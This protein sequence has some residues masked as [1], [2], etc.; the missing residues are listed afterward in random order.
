VR[1]LP[2][3]RTGEE[4]Q[5][6]MPH[7]CP[8]C[9]TEVVRAEGEAATRC[10]NLNCPARRLS[11][12]LHWA[13]RQAMDIDGLGPAVAQQLLDRGLAKTP[14]DLYELTA[15]EV[16][17]LEGF[18][19]KSAE[20]LVAAIATSR[21]ATLPR[22]VFALGIPQ[23]GETTAEALARA[24]G[25]IVALAAA[26][27]EELTAVEGVGPT[28]AAAVRDFFANPRNARLVERLRGYGIDPRLEVVRKEPGP[29]EG[30]TVVFTG[31]L[32]L[33]RDEMTARARAAGAKVASSVSGKTDLVVA[34]RDA[35]SK[36]DKAR[37]LGVEVVGEEEFLRRL[38][39]T[40]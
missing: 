19:E 15:D 18:A 9:G 17:S 33:P 2:E 29:L 5:F 30:L 26:S 36:L 28:V 32:G 31:A 39:E 24:F 38:G 25:G 7:E 1:S 8:V 16:G 21:S 4:R 13:G 23:V 27:E 11:L 10:P 3:K 35:G 14:L 20:N 6:S 12:L 22:L 40:A 37:G 34:G